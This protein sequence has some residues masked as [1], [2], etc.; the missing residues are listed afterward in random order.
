MFDI[1]RVRPILWRT[2]RPEE[3]TPSAPPG[4]I[5]SYRAWQDRFHAD[6]EVIGR[7]IRTN[8]DMTTIVGVMPK[9]FDFPLQM[10]AWLPL[11]RELCILLFGVKPWDPAVFSLVVLTLSASGLIA[12]LIPALR[13]T[14]VN[15]I[16]AL[17][18]E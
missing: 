16:E 7:A 11:S 14:R 9:Q 18:Y 15:P 8:S 10:D 17:R 3:D 1:L 13:A 2:F 4:M 5:L 12:C 6:P